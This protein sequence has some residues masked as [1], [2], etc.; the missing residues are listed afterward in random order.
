MK[1][2]GSKIAFIPFMRVPFILCSVPN[3]I[4]YEICLIYFF[5]YLL[6]DYDLYMYGIT[7]ASDSA[8]NV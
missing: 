2:F 1:S 8:G 6:D 5:F 4:S 7:Q 3:P